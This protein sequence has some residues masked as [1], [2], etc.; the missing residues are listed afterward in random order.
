M[1]ITK[2]LIEDPA[3][4]GVTSVSVEYEAFEMLEKFK[5]DLYETFDNRL[6]SYKSNNQSK[7]FIEGFIVARSILEDILDK[8]EN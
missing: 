6:C 2:E 4:Q 5:K 7:D 1:D 8:D 3:C